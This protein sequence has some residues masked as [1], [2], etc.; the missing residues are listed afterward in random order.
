MNE[1]CKAMNYVGKIGLPFPPRSA[2]SLDISEPPYEPLYVTPNNV[3]SKKR[4][5]EFCTLYT[6]PGGQEIYLCL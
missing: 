5:G 2:R 6:V 4:P 3:P 1:L